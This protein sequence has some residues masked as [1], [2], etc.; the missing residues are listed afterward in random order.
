MTQTP[1]DVNA[2]T[3]F[4]PFAHYLLRT[5]RN[6]GQKNVGIS[7]GK[8]IDIRI[9]LPIAMSGVGGVVSFYDFLVDKYTINIC[10]SAGLTPL[11]RP[12]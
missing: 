10:T 1:L 8:R 3:P 9:N 4:A 2:R 6:I 7:T 11:I 12:A 5:G